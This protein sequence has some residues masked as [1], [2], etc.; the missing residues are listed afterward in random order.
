[1]PKVCSKYSFGNISVSQGW[2]RGEKEMKGTIKREQSTEKIK[3]AE[4]RLNSLD[5]LKN[6]F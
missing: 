6:L 1:M 5:F 2:K 3:T 4:M